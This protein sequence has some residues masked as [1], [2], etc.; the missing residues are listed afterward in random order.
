MLLAGVSIGALAKKNSPANDEN[1]AVILG[2]AGES[3]PIYG[4]GGIVV[5]GG[6]HGFFA[7]NMKS[8]RIEIDGSAIVPQ[9]LIPMFE[10]ADFTA[11]PDGAYFVRQSSV[12]TLPT[13]GGALGQE[14]MI[15]NAG[16]GVTVTYQTANGE[17]LFGVEQLGALLV[18]KTQGQVDR[19]I[20]D[21]KAWYKE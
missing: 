15:C 10:T 16:G 20:S 11:A 14:I 9:K 19:I 12:C 21:G 8:S 18:N 2:E 13:A 6:H 17:S 3:Y 5:R 7:T 4:V 1:V